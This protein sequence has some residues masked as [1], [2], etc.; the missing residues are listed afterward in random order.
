MNYRHAFH[1]GNFADLAKHAVL[2]ALLRDLT[3]GPAALTVIDTHA[4]AGLYDLSAEAARRTREGE[5]GVARLMADGAAPSAFADL[6]AAVR[7]ANAS[8]E[9]RYYPGSPLIVAGFLRPRDRAM[10]CEL[11]DDDASILK[12]ALPR[13]SG[14]LVHRG[15]G[16]VYAARLAPASPTPLIVLIDPPFE[17]PDDYAQAVR[18]AARVLARNPAAVVAVWTPIKD[19]AT[20]DAFLGDLEDAA[21]AAGVLIAE[22]RLRPLIDPM[23]LNG[24]AMVV[25]NAPPVLQDHARAVVDWIARELGE[26]GAL[27]RVQRA[28]LSSGRA[29]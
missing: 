8:S 12:R 4:G 29:G 14:A 7:R 1:A 20:F 5:G 28:S 16:W 27:G 15:D 11:R 24:C 6:K 10:F 2:T 13:E 3:S 9:T 17:A 23:R 19:L 26:A 22:V 25:I 18:L 21:G